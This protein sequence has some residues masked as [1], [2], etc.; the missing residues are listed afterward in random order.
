MC[1][2]VCYNHGMN[3]DTKVEKNPTAVK[4]SAVD[5]CDKCGA[6]AYVKVTFKQGHLLFC[7]HHYKDNRAKLDQ[8]ALDVFNTADWIV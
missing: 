2:P 1:R 8:V 3:T 6:Q 5:R 4:M 7:G